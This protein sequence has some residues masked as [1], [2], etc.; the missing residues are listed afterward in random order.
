[1]SDVPTAVGGL[2][3]FLLGACIGSFVNVV[4]YRLPRD[5]SIVTPR[6]TCPNCA[7]AIPPWT[8]IPIFAYLALRGRCLLCHGSIPLRYFLT[9]LGLALAGIYLY[10]AFALP[11]AVAR[12]VLCAA[13]L[14]AS[15]V[16][17]DW[18]IIPDEISLPAIPAGLA[19]A[20]FLMPEV[21]WRSA[22]VGVVA[23]GGGLFLFG[24]A[25]RLLRKREGMGM[26]DVKLTAMIGAFLG[27]PAVLFTLFAGSILGAVGGILH[28]LWL[29]RAGAA[30]NGPA[31]AVA[32]L[33]G[34]EP[35][36]ADD[37]AILQHA[38]PFGP[39]LSIAAGYYALFQ[40]Q[41]IHWYLSR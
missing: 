14:A 20:T 8:N 29:R 40:P 17:F 41:L 38:V 12:F 10:F 21:G 19:A 30:A 2:F 23:G 37:V 27:W 22:S 26:G 3:A 34:Q 9:E 28:A 15:L 31:A 32:D 13:L 1:M 5:L 24:E 35:A 4:A 16:D 6:S 39:F 11:D 33:S 36:E 18:R 7:R 25:Y